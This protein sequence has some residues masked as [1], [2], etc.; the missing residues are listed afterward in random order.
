MTL[1]CFPPVSLTNMFN[2]PDG[3]KEPSQ[4]A[5]VFQQSVHFQMSLLLSLSSDSQSYSSIHC[6]VLYCSTLLK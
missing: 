5:P 6:S 4:L 3:K 1:C 2:L